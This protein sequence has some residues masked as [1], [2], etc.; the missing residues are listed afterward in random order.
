M[1]E[2][3][4]RMLALAESQFGVVTI[5]QASSV[6]IAE[7][8]L[9]YQ[10]QLGRLEAVRP[11]VLRVVGAAPTWQQRTKAVTLWLGADSTISHE[12]AVRLLQLDVTPSDDD[13][14]VSLI[15]T[16]CRARSAAD[17]VQHRTKD[18]PPGQRIFVGGIA[19][20]A[21]ART[22]VDVAGR[23]RG[24]DIVALAESARRL[25]LMSIAELERTVE[26]C[27]QRR[28]RAALAR[29][30]DVHRDQPALD[31]RLEVKAASMLRRAGL[32]G[33]VGQY[34]LVAPNGR[35]YRVDF[36]WPDRRV[37]IECDG[38]RWHGQH[39]SWKRDR[40]RI[41]AIERGGWQVVIVTWE[42]VTRHRIETLERVRLALARAVA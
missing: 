27:G 41:A 12:S 9:R 5:A 20:T 7:H 38:F 28:G 29:Y 40:R 11:R 31:H 17:V 26:Q 3:W 1:D 34:R 2:A 4:A 35:V 21:A 15:G 39:A 24:E 16:S 18:L 22:V 32:G 36:A 33:F 37:V 8:R 10:T 25:G 30:L 42:D 23:R 14:H 19:T 13:V 6:G